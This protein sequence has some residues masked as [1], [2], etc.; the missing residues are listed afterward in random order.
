MNCMLV[1]EQITYFIEEYSKNNGIDALIVGVSGGVDSALVSTLCAMTKIKTYCMIL[2]CHSR[3]LEVYRAE[4]HIEKLRSKFENVQDYT[5]NLSDIFN[6]MIYE[7][8]FDITKLT[9][10]NLKS[11]LRMCAL[12]SLAN[13]VGGIVVG[14]GNKVEDYG[15]GFFTKFGDGGV[16]ISPIGDLYKSEVQEL[17]AYLNVDPEIVNAR[18]TDGLWEDGRNDEDQLGI[19]YAK[20]DRILAFANGL[21]KRYY[22]VYISN[23]NNTFDFLPDDITKEEFGKYLELH[24]KSRHKMK[25]P[26]VCELEKE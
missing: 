1:S 9:E 4:K 6:D 24:M 15:I 11:R 13:S 20:L 2:P 21:E 22:D 25:M 26:P 8:P 23:P 7:M 10:A 12:Y 14:T 5:I 3:N 18:P 17:A 19:S 16:D